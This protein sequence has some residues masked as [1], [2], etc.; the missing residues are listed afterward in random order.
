MPW[1]WPWPHPHPNAHGKAPRPQDLDL[2]YTTP[3]TMAMKLE[4][5]SGAS[6][7]NGGIRSAGSK[8]CG[9]LFFLVFFVMGVFATAAIA[10]EAVRETA[11][12][13]WPEVPC[14]ILES[15]VEDTGDDS[16][17]YRP[18]IRF[19][20]E[21]E[22]RTIESREV[23]RSG[24]ASSSY[25]TARKPSYAYPAGSDATCR[26]NP[27]DPSEAVLE[28]RLP[29]VGLVVFLP[30]IFVAV[31]AGGLYF[32]WKRRGHSQA[33]G[34]V[35]SI[36]Q[37][38]RGAK[39]LGPKVELAV[40]L[41]FAAVGG[42]LSIFLLVIPATKLINALNWTETPAV[43]ESSTVRSWSTDDGTTHKADV[44]YAYEAGGRRWLS[45]RRNFFSMSSSD[46]GDSR[47]VVESYPAGHATTCFVDPDDPSQSVLDRRLR[48]VHLIGL[49]PLFFLVAGLAL[50]AHSRRNRPAASNHFTTEPQSTE[51]TA[52]QR[53][54][55]PQTGPIAK[56]LAMLFA[57]V[58]WNGIV[59]I[60]VWQAV[61]AWRSGSPEWFLMVFLIPFVLVGL[62]LI[63]GIFY[64]M[65]ASVNPKPRLV[66]S[67][68]EPR[69]GTHL[70]VDWS[71]TGKTNRL[72]N[73]KVILEGHER[74]TYRR[75]T[76]TYTDRDVFASL[77]L[78]ETSMEWEIPKGSTEIEIPEDTMHSFTSSN[79]AVVWS[80]HLHGD[81][82]R[83]PDV[84]ETFEF[85]VRPIS[86]ERLLP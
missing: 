6:T 51:P 59:S 13:F 56:I 19:E 57:A 79:N 46:Y 47:E 32:L 62:G 37:R 53:V 28:R 26:V 24:T 38:A 25:D 10:I 83:W 55:E 86:K 42:A 75:G 52:A 15:G 45:N 43:V 81:I 2:R 77:E 3:S 7:T 54:L 49:F 41:V 73:L 80:I 61:K 44:L 27:D 9:T 65:L 67:P 12:W 60:F 71:F 18:T 78:V 40:G 4:F 66:I 76:D 72:D 84:D 85:E 14:R 11:V 34:G 58:F 68:A 82:N 69:L 16:E 36:S 33:D 21:I 70:R 35:T 20:Y 30:L 48:P 17:P 23:A 64:T 74:A 1:Q 50:L 5:G 31:G 39:N 29:W 8:G 63:V 22:G